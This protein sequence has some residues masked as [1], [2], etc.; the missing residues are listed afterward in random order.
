MVELVNNMYENTTFQLDK[1]IEDFRVK[2]KVSK[3]HPTRA[4]IGKKEGLKVDQ[5]Y[6]VYQYKFDE[7][8]G[9]VSPERQ[10]VVRTTK[11]IVD[12]RTVATGSSPESSFYQT[13]GGTIQEGMILQQRLDFGISLMPGFE[14]GGIGGMDLG[15]MFRTGPL[16]K[17]TAL[18]ILGDIGFGTGDYITAFNTSSTKYNFLRYSIGVGKGFRFARIVELTPYVQYGIESTKDKTYEIISTSYI[19]LGAMLGFNI[20]H[21]ISLFGQVNN[22]MPGSTTVKKTKDSSA[23]SNFT[24]SWD[25]YF[26]GRTGTS[27]MIGLRFE[28]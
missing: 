10:A 25:S 3:V 6:F 28:F 14:T 4:K 11:N 26:T 2:V 22:Y 17:V 7:A 24:G 18:Y 21:N 8:K 16:T 1:S 27:I 5:Q 15:L 23:E 13:Y 19:K 9:T 12:N 20:A